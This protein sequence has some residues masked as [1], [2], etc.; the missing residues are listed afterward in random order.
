VHRLLARQLKKAF[1]KSENFPE[2]LQRLIETVNDAYTEND[3]DRAMIERSMDI[4]SRELFERNQ[5]LAVA[6]K[7]FREIFEN[8]TEGI[9]HVTPEGRC[10]SANRAMAEIC[11]YDTPAQLIDFL[12]LQTS[13]Y[14]DPSRRAEILALIEQQG[15]AREC[16][17][18]WRRRDGA[19]VWVAET[20]R[21]VRHSD[22][23]VLYYEGVVRNITQRK[24]VEA[25]HEELQQK[26]L[27]IS[28]RAGMAEVATG[29]LHNVGNVLNSINVAATL[30]VKTL[31]QSELGSLAKVA[32]M[33]DERRD[34]ISQFLSEDPRGKLVP[35]FL[36]QLSGCL[37]K[38]RALVREEL[39]TLVTG[40]EHIKQIINAQQ[41]LAKHNT[42][43]TS[44][45]PQAIADT[46]IAMQ[47]GTMERASIEIA[48]NF[49]D[50]PMVNLDQH[51][52]LQILINLLSNARHAVKNHITDG[53][54]RITL[55]VE[56]GAQ[57][58]LASVRFLVTDTGVGI[59]PENQAKLFAHGFTTRTEGHGFGLHSCA[60]AAS[61][62]RGTLT[63]QSD[64]PGTGATFTLEIPVTVSP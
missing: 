62:M 23:H 50:L 30:V 45:K 48:R 59:A 60:N 55:G 49:T 46:A 18:Q 15:L 52:V 51:K 56:S 37:E 57:S 33:I 29:V 34:T 4:S 20:L 39:S 28:R 19:V 5:D 17:S 24:R 44:I 36:V 31:E 43:L 41:S 26:L 3:N 53:P 35:N 12:D 9:F 61:E 22:G 27:T 42:V 38:E 64:G 63:C 6:E 58:P 14:V 1:G 21:P 25:E 54:R 32:Q 40:V 8:V 47:I 7:K 11:G 13:L 2:D 10:T 16:Q